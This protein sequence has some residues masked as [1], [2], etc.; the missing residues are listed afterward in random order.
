MRDRQEGW[1]G[2]GL[3]Q[4]PAPESMQAASSGMGPLLWDLRTRG[5]QQ[6]AQAP[7]SVH[8]FKGQAGAGKELPQP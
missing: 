7:G 4:G 6:V 1:D 5:R 2:G 3:G 8:I